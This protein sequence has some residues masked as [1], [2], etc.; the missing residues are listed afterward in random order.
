MPLPAATAAVPHYQNIL[1]QDTAS[2]LQKGGVIS[3]STGDGLKVQ[4]KFGGY[5][6]RARSRISAFFS[7]ASKSRV[8]TQDRVAQSLFDK[9]CDFY[10]A[11]GGDKKLCQYKVAAAMVGAGIASIR[12]SPDGDISVVSTGR[13][14]NADRLDKLDTA[15][16][17][18]PAQLAYQLME[19]GQPVP[20]GFID[21]ALVPHY[22]GL[23]S[24]G[25][26]LS[27]QEAEMFAMNKVANMKKDYLNNLV[28]N[29]IFPRLNQA[30]LSPQQAT[31]KAD[32][33]IQSLKLQGDHSVFKKQ[34][35]D[36]LQMPPCK[37]EELNQKFRS[38]L[39]DTLRDTPLPAYDKMLPE[40]KAD[41]M[42]GSMK[43]EE[44][45][46][47]VR[48]MLD[49]AGIKADRDVTF[50]RLL[51][52]KHQFRLQHPRLAPVPSGHSFPSVNLRNPQMPQ[53]DA[54][55][56]TPYELDQ[57][58]IE[59]IQRAVA[60]GNSL[61]IPKHDIANR[62]KRL[63]LRNKRKIGL[64]TTQ[65]VTFTVIAGISTGG[66]GAAAALTGQIGGTV[67]VSGGLAALH[68]IKGG[69]QRRQMEKNADFERDDQYTE[70]LDK[71][72][73]EVKQRFL[74]AGVDP[75]K[76]AS[77]LKNARYFCSH[78]GMTNAFNAYS[79]LE[80][81]YNTAQ[82]L[83]ARKDQSTPAAAI[84][85]EEATARVQYRMQQLKQHFNPYDQ[86]IVASVQDIARMDAEMGVQLDK[87]WKERF[88]G[89]PAYQDE[90]GQFDK[91][92]V[93]ALFNYAAKD[94]R[95]KHKKWYQIGGDDSEWVGKA[96]PQLRP[97]HDTT[98]EPGKGEAGYRTEKAKKLYNRSAVKADRGAKY[99]A[100]M[101]QM[102]GK[103]M[104]KI[105]AINFAKVVGSG[106]KTGALPALAEGAQQVKPTP[107]PEYLAALAGFYIA[108]HAAEKANTK[109][110]NWQLKTGRK[111][112]G[113]FS[114]KMTGREKVGV[115]RTVGKANLEK[116]MNNLQK[117]HR[118]HE[119]LKRFV[120]GTSKRDQIARK[121][122]ETAGKVKDKA[123]HLAD[124][125]EL[126]KGA[127]LPKGMPVENLRDYELAVMILRRERYK[128][129]AEKLMAQGIADFH[130]RVITQTNDIERRM[131]DLDVP[132]WKDP[133][134]DLPT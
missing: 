119:D 69:Q 58:D 22:V 33:L 75:K 30:E 94:Y 126:P 130:D 76:L 87:L 118:D 105:G 108:N 28:A 107:T 78:R 68:H 5:F 70:E 9:Y 49:S 3:R 25:E 123:Q 96:V 112:I 81:D 73:N 82:K 65:A 35:T 26:K 86:M 91:D 55:Q 100:G 39:M 19:K 85:G 46:K 13:A 134:P 66:I 24:S 110:N 88:E 101:A 38:M 60:D 14:V 45:E 128:E 8:T 43:P 103:D 102:Y 111:G 132:E 117:M 1:G 10:A 11:K 29:A 121:L 31:V 37:D 72:T 67:A 12:T 47:A 15:L 129:E 95:V 83:Q 71:V 27:E 131:F 42:A 50:E 77:F 48:G 115:A 20:P 80:R 79:E 32:E 106:I 54:P 116:F 109:V 104:A 113:P 21:K 98:T 124:K 97:E 122:D 63:V 84:K 61:Y 23:L 99:F 114:K 2:K 90:N 36:L 133:K 34:V 57:E 59:Y 93:A 89:N 41:I 56:P 18:T 62:L 44:A 120:D 6:V 52:L 64:F 92:K 127:K 17:S 51:T 40:I 16:R 4:S 74:A 125:A 7:R 53:L